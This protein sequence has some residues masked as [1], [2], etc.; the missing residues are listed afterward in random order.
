ARAHDSIDV[1]LERAK[2]EPFI[3]RADFDSVFGKLLPAIEARPKVNSHGQLVFLLQLSIDVELFVVG[4]IADVGHTVTPNLRERIPGLLKAPLVRE[5]LRYHGSKE[6]HHTA[7]AHMPVEASA[8]I[9]KKLNTS[10]IRSSGL[11]ALPF[12]FQCF[13]ASRSFWIG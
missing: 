8:R 3:A 12:R 2:P 1:T 4:H 10:D 7:T 11:G 5:G 9:A 6:R 13:T